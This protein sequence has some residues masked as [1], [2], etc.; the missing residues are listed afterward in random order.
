MILKVVLIEHCVYLAKDRPVS[1]TLARVNSGITNINAA[2]EGDLQVDCLRELLALHHMPG[3]GRY[4]YEII[5][6]TKASECDAS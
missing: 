5:A 2:A 3:H 4:R 6:I 1:A